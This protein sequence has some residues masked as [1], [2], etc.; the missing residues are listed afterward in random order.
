[1]LKITSKQQWKTSKIEYNKVVALNKD[2]EIPVA[3]PNQKTKEKWRT[4][5]KESK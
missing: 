3:T 2:K 4:V 1:M 5:K